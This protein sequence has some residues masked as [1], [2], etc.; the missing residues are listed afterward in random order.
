MCFRFFWF[1][2]ISLTLVRRCAHIAIAR[3]DVVA[4]CADTV[5]ACEVE[6]FLFDT[7]WRWM[8]I[9]RC[10]DEYINKYQPCMRMKL[11][12]KWNWFRKIGIKQHNAKISYTYI[13]GVPIVCMN[14]NIFFR[15][16]EFRNPVYFFIWFNGK[17]RPKIMF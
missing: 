7:F 5:S 8:M 16:E 9:G 12:F 4:F 13:H 1:V 2:P 6:D 17:I 14:L 10:I 3:Y 15:K 11:S